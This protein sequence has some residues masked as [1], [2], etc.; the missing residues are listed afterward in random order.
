MDAAKMDAA[1]LARE[2]G[3][4]RYKAEYGFEFGEPF[5]QTLSQGDLRAILT[6]LNRR[7]FSVVHDRRGDVDSPSICDDGHEE[8]QAAA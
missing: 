2:I 3:N 7:G 6:A 1:K 4:L 8:D 5:Y